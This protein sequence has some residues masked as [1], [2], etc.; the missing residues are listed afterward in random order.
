M[1]VGLDEDFAFINGMIAKPARTYRNR[2]G[3]GRVWMKI[4]RLLMVWSQN[5]PVPIKIDPG[6][7]GLDEDFAFINGMVAKPARTYRNRSGWGG[8]G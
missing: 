3:W 8:F 1:G 2:S 5:P 7:A 6:G 4:S